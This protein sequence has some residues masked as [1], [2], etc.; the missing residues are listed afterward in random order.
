MPLNIIPRIMIVEG[1]GSN[2]K[3]LSSHLEGLALPLQIIAATDAETAMALL[4][5]EPADLAIID[6]YLRGKMD[7]FDLCRALRSSVSNPQLPIILLLAGYLSLERCKGISAGADLLLHRPVIKE[8]LLK[9]V[10]LLLGWRVNQAGTSRL[11]TPENKPV[12]R[13]RSAS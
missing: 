4:Q 13:L 5:K 10:Q 6:T 7:G 3:S 1:Y 8:E 9:M 11:A 12:Q 2:I